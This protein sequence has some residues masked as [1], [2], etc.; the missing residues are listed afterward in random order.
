MPIRA[1]FFDFGGVLYFPPQRRSLRRWQSLLGLKN[2]PMINELFGTPEQSETVRKVFTGEISETEIEERLARRWGFNTA[3][4]RW[5][6][7]RSFSARRFNQPLADFISSLRPRYRTAI[8][9]NAGD[10]SRRILCDAY[11]LDQ[12]VDQVIISAEVG[13]AKPDERIYRLAL[14]RLAV[15]PEESLF[16]DDLAINIEAARRVGMQTVQF[17][18][19]EQVLAELGGWISVKNPLFD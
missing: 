8:L 5:L 12:V 10:Q 9:S 4:L 15:Q 3:L 2:D 13:L 1:I 11:H 19:T 18:S 17:H 7:R 6:R 14:E 16:V